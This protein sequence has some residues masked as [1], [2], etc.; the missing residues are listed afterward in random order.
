MSQATSAVLCEVAAERERQDAKW[1]VQNHPSGTGGEGEHWESDTL[2]EVRRDRA[3]QAINACDLAAS[4]KR[5]TWRHILNEELAEA[6]AEDESADLRE[7]L[8]QV[9]AVAVGWIECIDRRRAAAPPS[10]QESGPEGEVGR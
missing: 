7:E 4:Q 5:L 2:R 9:A 3:K 8:V 10:P 6:V 1:G